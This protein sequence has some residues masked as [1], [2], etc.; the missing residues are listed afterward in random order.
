MNVKGKAKSKQ[1]RITFDH[2]AI[3]ELR[4]SQN[5]TLTTAGEKIELSRKAVSAIENGRVYL[6]RDRIEQIVKAYGLTYFDFVTVR[7]KIEKESKK[8][9]GRVIIRKVLS[10]SDRRSYQKIITKEVRVLRS[11]RKMKGLSQYKAC[12]LCGYPKATIGHIENGRIDISEMRIK[13][14]VESYGYKF[15]DFEEYLKQDETKDI[16]IEKC[17]D[18]MYSLDKCK[19]D[20]VNNL[21]RSL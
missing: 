6:G 15:S 19:L 21:I 8:R 3:R 17:I 2:Q 11:M 9:K 18:K 1:K 20:L 7:K 14:I 13:H 12:E 4:L 10:N 5:L 16:M